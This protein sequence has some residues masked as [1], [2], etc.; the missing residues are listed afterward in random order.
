MAC[1]G[2]GRKAG[3]RMAALNGH[4][5]QPLDRPAAPTHFRAPFASF[6]ETFT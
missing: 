4:S 6:P 3:A 2:Q 1:T 5:P